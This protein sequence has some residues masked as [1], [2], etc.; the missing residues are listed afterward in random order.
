MKHHVDQLLKHK[1]SD[2]EVVLAQLL[3]IYEDKIKASNLNWLEKFM[4]IIKARNKN[5]YIQRVACEH[6]RDGSKEQGGF[7]NEL[8]GIFYG[9]SNISMFVGTGM[10]NS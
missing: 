10:G 9:I 4:T 5:I 8:L 6:E 3:K 2:V 7:D 1:I